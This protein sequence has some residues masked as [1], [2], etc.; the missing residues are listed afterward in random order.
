MGEDPARAKRDVNP[1]VLITNY[2][3]TT[4]SNCMWIYISNVYVYIYIHKYIY[5]YIYIKKKKYIHI[6]THMC[7]Y[8]GYV[9]DAYTYT[10]I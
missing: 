6:F 7:I 4:I 9:I 3:N 1:E 5:I 2:L 10:Y 8:C